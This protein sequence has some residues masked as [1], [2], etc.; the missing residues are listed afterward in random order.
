M[1]DNMNLHNELVKI[2]IFLALVQFEK[3]KYEETLQIILDVKQ[4]AEKSNWQLHTI[5]IFQLNYYETMLPFCIIRS[6]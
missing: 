3:N 1:Y 2:Y 5:T 6:T 4:E